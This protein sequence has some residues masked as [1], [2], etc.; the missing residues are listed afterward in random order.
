MLQHRHADFFGRARVHGGFVNHDIARLE[1]A[2]HGFAGLDQRGQIG[3]VG[4]IYRR[5]HG[6]DENPAIAQIL[7]IAAKAQLAGRL[8]LG[9]LHFQR[10]VVPGLQL[11]NAGAVDIKPDY[12]AHVA[13]GNSQRQA[14]ITKPDD[15]DGSVGGKSRNR[16]GVDVQIDTG[17][18]MGPLEWLNYPADVRKL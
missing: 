1:R 3:V 9:R 11:G 10:A 13:K 7:R 17:V 2:A 16:H 18:C 4:L 8:Q 5:G 6:H 12:R 14:D 15:G